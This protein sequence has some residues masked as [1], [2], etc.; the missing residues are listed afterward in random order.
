MAEDFKDP[1]KLFDPQNLS[2]AN[3]AI[4]NLADNANNLKKV[5]EEFGDAFGRSFVNKINQVSRD[6]D[7]IAARAG[8][9]QK[10]D[11]TKSEAM[12]MQKKLAIDL[13]KLANEEA[14]LKERVEGT[15]KNDYDKSKEIFD[16]A[17]DRLQTLV[18]SGRASKS[19]LATAE[20][21]KEAAEKILKADAGAY[22]LGQAAL[23]NLQESLTRGEKLVEQTGDYVANWNKARLASGL[24]GR[25]LKGLKKIP[26]V[27]DLIDADTMLTVMNKNLIKGDGLFKA[28]GKGVSAAF[29]GIEK[30]TIILALIGAVVKAIKFVVS[31]V[32]LVNTQTVA[33]AKNLGLS[34][35]SAANLRTRF[36]G[37]KKEADETRG[38]SNNLLMTTEELG[39]AQMRVS[40]A[41]G[42]V[43]YTSDDILR[44]QID[45]VKYMGVSEEGA[46]NIGLLFQSTGVNAEEVTDQITASNNKLTQ[47]EQKLMPIE[48]IMQKIGAVSAEI[49]SYFGNSVT[50]LASGVRQV[51][52]FGLGLQQALN[53]SKSL[54][55]FES[56]I[57]NE[58]NAEILLNKEFNFEKARSLAMQGKIGEAT[59]EVMSQMQDLTEEQRRSPIYLEAA[60]KAAG[61]NADELAKSFQIQKAL[62]VSTEQYAELR[63][64]AAQA[65][66]LEEFERG[67]LAGKTVEDLRTQL[68]FSQKLQAATAKLKEALADRLMENN[69]EGI[70]AI[71]DKLLNLIDNI[72]RVATV[73]DAI[74]IKPLTA[75]VNLL[76]GA[77]KTLGSIGKFLIGDF[78]GAGAMWND[79]GGDFAKGLARSADIGTNLIVGATGEGEADYFTK[80]ADKYVDAEDFTIRTHPKDTLVM[81]GGTQLGGGQSMEEVVKSVNRLTAIVE[82]GGNVYINGNDA[83]KAL[84]L[85]TSR[86]S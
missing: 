72:D 60:A 10:L 4:R 76:S 2:E 36:A 57:G 41:L 3:S 43:Q 48:S 1:K 80:R 50:E 38:I 29:K 8:D 34:T 53:I 55:D 70:D 67:A 16:V 17:K 42:F 20:A 47:Q 46:A 18:E 74:V 33:L 63:A 77:F 85:G 83:G 52:K 62:Q 51:A 65:G 66:M 71:V 27:G 75:V 22:E 73:I 14:E 28:F 69:G 58:L 68:D 39:K 45:L 56:S 9:F 30:S 64:K 37:I 12:R 81:A 15:L 35:D 79:A 40:K 6:F 44:N 78:S 25:T 21:R 24:L 61:V 13:A 19:Q 82:K 59:E 5:S 31:L 23:A 84:V 49:A 32:D 86:L 11:V 7:N 54:L 26:L